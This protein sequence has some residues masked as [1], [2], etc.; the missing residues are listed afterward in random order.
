MRLKRPEE[1]KTE[2]IDLR[3]TKSQKNKIKTKAAL[4]NEGNVTDYMIYASLHFVPGKEDFE[5]E[6][7][8]AP[9]RMP[10]KRE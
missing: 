7:K 2:R 4:Y 1:S 5:D 6:I 10:R 3:M 9:R 8:R